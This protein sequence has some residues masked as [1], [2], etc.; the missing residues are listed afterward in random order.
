MV[1]GHSVEM[2][3][4]LV[5]FSDPVAK[6]DTSW[7]TT[8]KEAK[9]FHYSAS[10]TRANIEAFSF[11]AIAKRLSG[12]KL[13]PK[14]IEGLSAEGV[15]Y[16]LQ[17]SSHEC[18]FSPDLQ[19]MILQTDEFPDHKFENRLEHV[20][21]GEPDLSSYKIPSGYHVRDIYLK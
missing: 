3:E 5:R 15:R 18:W 2:S 17:N 20:V 6:T 11:D 10:E 19:I 12:T 16:E 4:T 21:R 7:D 9:V 14:T 8:N 1:N 13:A